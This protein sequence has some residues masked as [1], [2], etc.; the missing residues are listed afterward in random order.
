MTISNREAGLIKDLVAPAGAALVGA[1]IPAVATTHLTAHVGTAA[2]TKILAGGTAKAVCCKAAA[3][4]ATNPI[5]LSIVA[6]ALI[7]YGVYKLLDSL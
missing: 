4:A 3:V 5:G 6:T 1:T 2:A 7:G